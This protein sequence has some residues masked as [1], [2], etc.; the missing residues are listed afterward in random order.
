MSL[1]PITAK[2]ERAVPSVILPAM[3]LTTQTMGTKRTRKAQAN[4]GLTALAIV[5]DLAEVICVELR[6]SEQCMRTDLIVSECI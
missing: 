5:S 6:R 3:T 1:S 4:T 2:A